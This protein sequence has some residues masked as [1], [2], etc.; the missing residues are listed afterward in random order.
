MYLEATE[1]LAK[2]TLGILYFSYPRST[3]KN[4][5][6][7]SFPPKRESDRPL[8]V[9]FYTRLHSGGGVLCLCVPSPAKPSGCCSASPG[10]PFKRP[11]YSFPWHQ[12]CCFCWVTV[13]HGCH[14]SNETLLSW[15]N[16]FH[17]RSHPFFGERPMTG[18]CSDIP[19]WFPDI[20]L[21]HL[22]GTSILKTLN[23]DQ[24]IHLCWLFF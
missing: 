3:N 20:K 19:I 8:R 9:K 15:K 24:R 1:R 2:M 23:I 10:W 5:F 22:R 21:R 17:T 11:R 7:S 6:I 14:H 4:T 13:D 12:G 18:D 16:C